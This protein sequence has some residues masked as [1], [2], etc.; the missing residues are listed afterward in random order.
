MRSK[1]YHLISGIL[2]LGYF[3]L[4]IFIFIYKKFFYDL[5]PLWGRILGIAFVVYGLFR[6]YRS[7]KSLKEYNE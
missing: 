7:L 4:G 1:S 3:I 6:I 2:G 5:E